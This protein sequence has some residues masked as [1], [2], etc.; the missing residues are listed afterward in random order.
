VLVPTGTKVTKYEVGTPTSISLV[1]PTQLTP[2]G[3]VVD[4][5]Y[6]LNSLDIVNIPSNKSFTVFN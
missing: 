5:A 6:N 1:N 2:S 3:F 4:N